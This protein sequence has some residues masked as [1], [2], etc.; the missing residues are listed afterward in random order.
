MPDIRAALA[1][2]G[3]PLVIAHRGDWSNAPENSCAAIRSAQ[4]F[5]MVEIDVQLSE[6]GVPVVVH[7][8][9]LARTTVRSDAVKALKAADLTKLHL[10]G[11][12]ETL[13][14]LSDALAVGGDGLLFDIDVKNPEDL[15]TVARFLAGHGGKARTMIKMDVWDGASL[16]ALQDLE[17]AFG[18]TVLAKVILRSEKDLQIIDALQRAGIA[19]CEVW[20]D[21]L[22]LLRNAARIGLPITTYTLADVHCA[23][24]SDAQALKDPG[25]VWGRLA[26]AGI[27]GVM[28]DAPAQAKTF[29]ANCS[30]VTP[31]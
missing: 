13:P 18:V 17:E 10:E 21:T 5:D 14:H 15:G 12:G 7:D 3:R 25:D 4:A 19:G 24:L 31:V 6:D 16:R 2:T 1:S 22:P 11:S 29:F 26:H 27:R 30:A 9:T 28:T 20:F 8:P 23:G